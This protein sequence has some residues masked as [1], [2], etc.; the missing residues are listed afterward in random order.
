MLNKHLVDQAARSDQP[1]KSTWARYH[2]AL[3]MYKQT[4][5]TQLKQLYSDRAKLGTLS[6]TESAMCHMIM[7]ATE[8]TRL[9]IAASILNN[10]GTDVVALINVAFSEAEAD[11][12]FI[13]QHGARIL[14]M[15]DPLFPITPIF[16]SL[17]HQLITGAEM[18]G[19]G[20]RD[21][22]RTMLQDRPLFRTT[23][24]RSGDY[25]GGGYIPVG[26][27]GDA[28]FADVTAIE[29]SVLPRLDQIEKSLKTLARSAPRTMKF[30][31]EQEPIRSRGGARGRG[32]RGRGGR[33]LGRGVD[34]DNDDQVS[35]QGEE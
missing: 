34:V 7:F 32:G 35:D 31:K 16:S 18:T 12:T 13:D 3:S 24:K 21:A 4:P 22:R 25:E 15:V 30:T 6:T 1:W 19:G 26:Q 17:N 28:M 11:A 2:K 29:Q 14:K 20:P 33:M 8:E 10:T 9:Q 27:I 5:I 23:T